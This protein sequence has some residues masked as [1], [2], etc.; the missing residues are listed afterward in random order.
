MHKLGRSAGPGEKAGGPRADCGRTQLLGGEIPGWVPR[1][2]PTRARHA[3]S[4]LH[5]LL[6]GASPCSHQWHCCNWLRSRLWHVKGVTA[7]P[8]Y[9]PARHPRTLPAVEPA[10]RRLR[11]I[12]AA[13]PPPP[14]AP[15]PA[16]LGDGDGDAAARPAH[17]PVGIC[18]CCRAQ[19]GD[20]EP[21]PR[22]LSSAMR[23]GDA[24]APANAAG[25]RPA[26]LG[27]DASGRAVR[28]LAAAALPRCAL[29]GRTGERG[30]G[31]LGGVS[32]ASKTSPQRVTC[33]DAPGAR[34]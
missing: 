21:P 23:L 7:W 17:A 19:C 26:A 20:G 28:S 22:P 1:R 31:S 32:G 25:G 6:H 18:A 13:A 27:D 16:R 5:A 12:F 24:A 34:G 2:A 30:C 3:Q 11:L 29:A 14:P 10:S 8:W 15:V 33:A 4:C 9:S